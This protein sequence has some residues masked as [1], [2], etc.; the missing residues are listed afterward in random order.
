MVAHPKAFEIAAEDIIGELAP[1]EFHKQYVGHFGVDSC[2]SAKIWDLIQ[3]EDLAPK[4]KCHH[5]LWALY[6]L[7]VYN[8]EVVLSRCIGVHPNT[9][10]KFAWPIIRAIANQKAKVVS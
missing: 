9:F 7:K 4:T 1:Y 10:R 8:T 2:V 5:L 3:G 6:L